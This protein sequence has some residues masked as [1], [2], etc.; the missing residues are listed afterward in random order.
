MNGFIILAFAC[1]VPIM[2]FLM[3]KLQNDK[4]IP[5]SKFALIISVSIA[6]LVSVLV[7]SGITYA[8]INL[9]LMDKEVHS[10]EIT[11]KDRVHG[12]YVETY[13]CNCSTDSNGNRRCQTCRRDHYTVEWMAY[14]NIGDFTIK[15]LDSTSRRVYQEPDPNRYTQVMIGEPVAAERRYRNYFKGIPNEYLW[16]DGLNVDPSLLALVPNYPSVYDFYRI[17]RV[18]NVSDLMKNDT[19]LSYNSIIADKLKTLGPKKEVNLILVVAPP[20]KSMKYAIREKWD[21]GKKNDVIV[22]LGMD[23]SVIEDAQI[24]TWDKNHLFS[25]K[26]SDALIEHGV[27]NDELLN[28]IFETIESDF[29]RPKMSEYDDLL[30]YIQPPW[31]AILVIYVYLFAGPFAIIFVMNHQPKR[32]KFR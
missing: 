27:L 22:I 9:Q 25:A 8:G 28:I 30:I 29:T 18:L 7:V 26:L 21:G 5:S 20:N 12:H 16:N 3:K 2:F 13:Q 32:R 10:G 31:W 23:D 4:H 6:S 11:K 15:K 1:I 24:L 19:V 17:D 14:S